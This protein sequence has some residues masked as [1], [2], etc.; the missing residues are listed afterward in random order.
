MKLKDHFSVNRFY[1]YLKYDLV[2]NGK[3]YLFV[4]I[5]LV[6][7][8]VFIH[9]FT[10]STASNRVDFKTS[11]YIPIFFFTFIIGLVVSG[12]TS[13]PALRSSQHSINF[14]LLP[15]SNL[16]KFIVQFLFRV[17]FFILLFVPLYWITFNIAYGIYG[18]FEWTNFIYLE[19]F[20][21]FSVFSEITTTLDKLATVFSIISLAAF[22]FAGATYFKKYA[23]FKTILAFSLLIFCSFLLMVLF[24]HIFFPSNSRDVFE[25]K[26]ENYYINKDLNNEQLFMYI[27]GMASSLF[28]LPLAYFKLKE[29][30]V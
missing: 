24:S 3:T 18:L 6:L 29:K 28:L 7:A 19:P 1:K 4:M 9:F 15:V 11:Y 13:F 22:A 23:F 5:G 17:L 12:G 2:L 16:E 25:V 8:L 26:I 20:E 21:L 14:L 10:L 27:F 30:E